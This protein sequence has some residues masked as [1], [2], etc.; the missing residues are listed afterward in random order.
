MDPRLATLLILSGFSLLSGYCIHSYRDSS[1]LRRELFQR[2][3]VLNDRIDVLT[4]DLDQW[5][6]KYLKLM[7]SNLT[8]KTEYDQLSIQLATMSRQNTNLKT[9]YSMLVSELRELSDDHF[10]LKIQYAAMDVQL[11][12]IK[13]KFLPE[14]HW[15]KYG[16]DK[17][18]SSS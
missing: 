1:K 15:S 9:K 17:D 11:E 5:K 13:R 6:E 2:Y 3:D 14:Q 8:L 10:K 16:Y 12:D 18:P 4:D 7:E